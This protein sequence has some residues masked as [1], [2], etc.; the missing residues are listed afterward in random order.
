ME[1]KL[2]SE[3]NYQQ[4]IQ[5]WQEAKLPY[6]PK[7]RD[8]QT[9]IS[10]SLE[11]KNLRILLAYQNS[12]LI[13]SVI[14]SHDN[15]KGWINR[16]AVHPR[17]WHQGIASKLIKKAEQILQDMN[18]EIYACLIKD[19]NQASLQLFKKN[20]YTLH[21]DITYLTKRENKDV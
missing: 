14:V 4:L 6:K 11:N 1:Y 19:W 18:I 17:Y 5:L 2:Y 21:D 20:G 7:G 13:G 10:D 12:E 15:R 16:L 9:S 8:S 3:E